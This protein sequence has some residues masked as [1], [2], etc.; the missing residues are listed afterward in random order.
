MAATIESVKHQGMSGTPCKRFVKKC[1]NRRIR[2]LGKKLLADAPNYKE[3]YG[4]GS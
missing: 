3:R 1:T 4:Y 2:R